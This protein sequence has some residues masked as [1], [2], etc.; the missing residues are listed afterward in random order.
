MSAQ[1]A[2]QFLSKAAHDLEFQHKFEQAANPQEF[3][4][5]AEELGFD[6]T[7]DEL[8]A[9]VQQNSEGVKVRRQTGVWRWLRN[10]NWI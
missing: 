10:V 7:P 1:S 8:K 4:Q 2:N 5:I 6:F 3:I 9:V